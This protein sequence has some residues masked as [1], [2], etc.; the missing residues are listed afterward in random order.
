[1]KQTNEK[2]KIQQ[3]EKWS[4]RADTPN[5]LTIPVSVM[6]WAKNCYGFMRESHT[7]KWLE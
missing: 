5:K 4:T 6:Q 3:K 1:M 2:N 7:G